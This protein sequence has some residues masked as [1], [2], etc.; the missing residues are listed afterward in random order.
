MIFKDI[1]KRYSYSKPS[2]KCSRASLGGFFLFLG[3]AKGISLVFSP[4]Y[5]PLAFR[6]PEASGLFMPVKS[7]N[8]SIWSLVLPRLS[9]LSRNA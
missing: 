9:I 4:F 2:K 3:K 5:N 8:I 7:V 1:D 6:K